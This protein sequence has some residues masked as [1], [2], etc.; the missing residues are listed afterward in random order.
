MVL[1]MITRMKPGAKAVP[2]TDNVYWVGAVDWSIRDFHGYLTSRGTT[3]NAYL[4]VADKITLVDTVKKP[5]YD[6][7]L[8]RIS[9]VVDPARIDIVVSNHAEMDHSG[10]LPEL[11]QLAQPEKV[12]CSNMGARILPKHFSLPCELTPVKEGETLDLGGEPFTFLETKLLHWPDSMFSYLP[13]QKLLFSQDAFGMH[14]A[15]SDRFDADVDDYVLKEEAAKY[16]ANILTP[17]SPLVQK[18]LGKVKEL[19][20]PLDVICPDHGPIWREGVSKILGLYDEWSQLLPT[21]K[22]VIVYDTMWHSTAEM[23]AAY[24]DGLH[25]GGACV[26]VL[27]L[28]STHRS[29]IATEL[30]DAG[31]LLIG[32]PTINGNLFPTVAD[33][34]SY[35]RGLK[36]RNLV[37][38]CFGSYGWSGEAV[39]Q[40]AEAMTEMKVEMIGEPVKCNWVPDAEVLAKC[41]EAGLAVAEALGPACDCRS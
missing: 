7:M 36:R 11:L 18:L 24:G 13:N 17:F 9:S 4:V 31:A 26:K 3:Y 6:E 40:V 19:N 28:N 27:P 34:L 12:Y 30:L 15:S 41:Y 5:F 37:G 1:E 23:A 2:V 32:S 8:A 20:L 38:T 22:A 33:I 16:Y 39:G 10:C 14:L 25:D 29:D 35:L 21:R